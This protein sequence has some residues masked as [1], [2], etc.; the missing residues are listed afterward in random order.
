MDGE[1]AHLG[2][3]SVRDRQRQTLIALADIL[4]QN[5]DVVPGESE[6]DVYGDFSMGVAVIDLNGYISEGGGPDAE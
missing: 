3:Y 6:V 4:I 5:T 1:L 2:A